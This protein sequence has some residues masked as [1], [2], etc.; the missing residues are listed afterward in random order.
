M[1]EKLITFCKIISAKHE[2]NFN[3]RSFL[4]AQKII[5]SWQKNSEI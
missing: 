5:A 2:I 1:K 3:D 4:T